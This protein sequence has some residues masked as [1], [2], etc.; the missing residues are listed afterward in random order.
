MRFMFKIKCKNKRQINK[1]HDFSSVVIEAKSTN[2]TS[3]GKLCSF[4]VCNAV[5]KEKRAS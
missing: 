2:N 3:V 5:F 4:L 1:T